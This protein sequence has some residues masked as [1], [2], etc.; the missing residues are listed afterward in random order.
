MLSILLA[1][2]VYVNNCFTTETSLG[3]QYIAWWG[4]V[5]MRAL[6]VALQASFPAAATLNQKRPPNPDSGIQPWLF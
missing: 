1:F 2:L 4:E 6:D 5:L 3:S